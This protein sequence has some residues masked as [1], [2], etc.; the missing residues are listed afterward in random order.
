MRIPPSARIAILALVL[1]SFGP[2][3]AGGAVPSQAALPPLPPLPQPVASLV[4]GSSSE[5]PADTA[6]SSANSSV[7]SSQSE[8]STT[9][10]YSQALQRAVVAELNRTRRSFGRSPLTLSPQLLRAGQEHARELAL[11][12]LFTHEWS[13]GAPFRSWIQLYYPPARTSQWRVG[14]NL[15]WSTPQLSAGHTIEMWLASPPHRLNLLD[16]RWSQIGIGVVEAFHA[17]GIYGGRDVVLVAA[18]FGVRR[19]P[20]R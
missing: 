16:R 2:L 7:A 12:G 20:R 19:G 13:N 11:H 10:R 3:A 15:A 8:R 9:A 14:E 5:T 6:D 1:F 18:E 4:G 17:G